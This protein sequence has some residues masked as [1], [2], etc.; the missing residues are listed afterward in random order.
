MI[1]FGI[2]LKNN[3]FL[4]SKWIKNNISYV[5]LNENNEDYYKTIENFLVNLRN[6]ND[7]NIIKSYSEEDYY[8]INEDDDY[9]YDFDYDISNYDKDSSKDDEEE[10]SYFFK[11]KKK[12]Y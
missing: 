6:N 4:L 8:S 7:N 9:D 3:S 1:C 12:K 2:E 10:N 11:N 5:D